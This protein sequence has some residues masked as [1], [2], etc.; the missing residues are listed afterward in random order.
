VNNRDKTYFI[1]SHFIFSLSPI[2]ILRFHISNQIATVIHIY[3][4]V[5]VSSHTVI[6]VELKLCKLDISFLPTVSLCGG[7]IKMWMSFS[8]VLLPGRYL[9]LWSKECC[10]LGHTLYVL[11]FRSFRQ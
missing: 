8:L 4:L 3:T 11:T 9:E 10:S 5:N 7:T 6:T 2:F 1:K